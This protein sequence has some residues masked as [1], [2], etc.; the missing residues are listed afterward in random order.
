MNNEYYDKIS[1]DQFWEYLNESIDYKINPVNKSVEDR[2]H[3]ILN[4]RFPDLHIQKQRFSDSQNE[5]S[6]RN[7]IKEE[8]KMDM[9]ITKKYQP[10]GIVTMCIDITKLRDEY[11]LLRIITPMANIIAD[12]RCDQTDGLVKCIK[13]EAIQLISFPETYR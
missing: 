8:L 6:P 12:F 9:K 7:R 5:G 13:E 10:T 11:Y 4:K 1:N 3:K 2:I